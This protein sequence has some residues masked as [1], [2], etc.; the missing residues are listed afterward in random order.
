M[1]D[2]PWL[3]NCQM[4]WLLDLN[5]KNSSKILFDDYLRCHLPEN[6]KG[7]PMA[8]LSRR[9]IGCSTYHFTIFYIAE[10][11]TA[12]NYFRLEVKP[13]SHDR[14]WVGIDDDCLHHDLC[15]LPGFVDEA[16]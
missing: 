6:L 14:S 12:L 8:H 9:T 5:K 4:A 10:V 1:G 11:S 3:C 15:C 2:N 13:K 7:I 16:L